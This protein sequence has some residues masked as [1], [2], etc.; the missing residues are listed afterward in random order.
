[1][2]ILFI[3]TLPD[4]ITGQSLAC[5]VLLDG[6]VVSHEVR[7]INLNKEITPSGFL[8]LTRLMKLILISFNIWRW[9]KWPDVIYFTIS[10]S[11]VG[12]LKDLVIYCILFRRL[13]KMVVHL[14]GGWGM[15]QIMFKKYGALRRLNSFFLKRFAGVII[16]GPRQVEI[17]ERFVGVERLHIVPNFAQD[18]LFSTEKEIKSKFA[19]LSKLKI[20]YL[21]N[22]IPSKG[23]SDLL[24]AYLMLDGHLQAR[25]QID[26][27]GHFESAENARVFTTRINNLSDIRYHGVVAGALKKRLL[28]EAHVFCLPTYYSHEGQPISILESYA[29][30]CVVITTDHSGICDVFSDGVNGYEVEK[31]SP[32]SIA[33]AIQ[34]ILNR[35]EDLCSI[36]VTNNK[37]AKDKYT[38]TKF[39]SALSAIILKAGR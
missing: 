36:S 27:A 33:Q 12:N 5:K 3:G 9:R 6:L 19:D 29:A 17:Y 10:E 4:P 34:L 39:I 11:V 20:L 1:M 26:F 35:P 37:A 31:Q 38:T 22:L 15:H 8:S 14:H 21:S 7:V 28:S 32:K 23:Y 24:D 2:R 13:S 18:Y 30:G 25:V 16:L